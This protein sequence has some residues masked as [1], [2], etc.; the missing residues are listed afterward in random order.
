[1]PLD[2]AGDFSSLTSAVTSSTFPPK[3]VLRRRSRKSV[4][5]RVRK[6]RSKAQRQVP[7]MTYDLERFGA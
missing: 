4:R 1:M 6:S 2:Q 7:G 5:A 3:R